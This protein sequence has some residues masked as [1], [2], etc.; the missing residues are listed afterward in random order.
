V[1]RLRR[2]GDQA[3]RL[4]W[5]APQDWMC[6]PAIINGGR[7]GPVVFAGTH[8]SVAEHQAR[9]VA[10]Y[11]TLRDLAPELPI[12]PVVQGWTLAD[13]LRCFDAYTAAGVDLTAEPLVGV[14]SV[15]RRQDTCEAGDILTAL[16]HAGVTRLHGFGFKTLGLLAHGH[17]LT[18]AD[19]LAWS[20]GAR[21]RPPL[22]ECTGRHRN[23]ANCPRYA[24]AWRTQLLAALAAADQA[25][26]QLTLPLLTGARVTALLPR[27]AVPI[28]E[29]A[30][31]DQAGEAASSTATAHAG[32]GG[33]STQYTQ[34]TEPDRPWSQAVSGSPRFGHVSPRNSRNPTPAPL[35][36]SPAARAAP[37][38]AA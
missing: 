6:E 25:G 18:S 36:R 32:D 21:R 27:P 8:L 20:Y 13:Y 4:A 30:G 28:R 26:R 23:C 34:Y 29:P 37:P 5:A 33:T 35:D 24:T 17:L 12:I 38:D 31:L 2:Y 10:N 7:F 11:L 1:A 19:S 14:G 16:H 9:T 3:G 15:C 22:P